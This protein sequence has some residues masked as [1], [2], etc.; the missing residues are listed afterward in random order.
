[1]DG[2]GIKGAFSASV[3]A[4]VEDEMGT[5]IGEYFDLVTGTSTGGILALGI[6]LRFPA[7]DMVSFYRTEGPRIFPAMGPLALGGSVR[8]LFRPR[9]SHENLRQAL[10]SILGERRFGESKSRLII[11]T[12]DAIGGRIFVLKT[13]HHPSL[14]YDFNALAVDVALATS[15]APTYFE[16]SAFPLHPGSSYID[17]GVWSNTPVLAAIAEAKHYLGI[18]LSEIEVLSVGTTSVPFNVARNKSAGALQWNIGM[19]DLMFEA[20]SEAAL[21]QANL[22]LDRRILR[23]NCFTRP[24]EYAL[25]DAAPA[26]IE[27][28]VNLGRSEAVKS[29][30]M[31]EV[32]ERF[33]KPGKAEPFVPLYPAKAGVQVSPDVQP[34]T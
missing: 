33:V 17:G 11:P 7:K 31:S 1:L 26:K 5:P 23:I 3:L 30:N 18:S 9:Y 4:A 34:M 13:A 24:G 15:S 22:L 12:Y 19:I 8:Q 32:L 2:G 16:A 28:L 14:K 20:Q 6:G 21:A 25:G 10:S 29:L 27:R